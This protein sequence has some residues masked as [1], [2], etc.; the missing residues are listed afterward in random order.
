[1]A[2]FN[3]PTKWQTSLVNSGDANTIPQST[4]VGTGEASFEDGFPQITQVP[5]GAGGIAP[6][7]KDFNGLFKILG[8]WIFFA[9]NGGLPTYSADFDYVAGR[10]VLYNGNLY[11]CIQA[12]GASSTVVAPDS[13]DTYWQQLDSTQS[14]ST[15]LIPNQTIISELPLTDVNLHLKDG[16]LL[17]GSG[18]YS[19][20]VDLIAELYNGGTASTSFC[21]EAEWQTSNTNYGFCNKFVYDSV[22]NTVRLPKVNSEHGALI[23]SYSS[24]TEWYRIY[25]DGWCEQGGFVTGVSDV[26]TV[27][28]NLDILFAD[29]S[30]NISLT[31]Y[32]TS[33]KATTLQGTI[34]VLNISQ[35]TDST[36]K[37]NGYTNGFYWTACGY[38]DISDLQTAPI[39]EYIVVG[40]VSKTDIQIDIDNILADLALKADKDFSN[41]TA[42]TQAF[43]DMSIGWDRPDW[44]AV[45]SQNVNTSYT[46]TSNGFIYIYNQGISNNTQT[47]TINGVS[48][49]V[50]YNGKSGTCSNSICVPVAK[51]DTYNITSTGGSYSSSF[52]KFI[53]CKGAN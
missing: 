37:V 53:P 50:F 11:K 36:F 2:V 48:Q 38:T 28:V 33:A 24:E 45:I 32:I 16:A 23:K 12:N 46:A 31:R 14:D 49:E 40:T 27:T 35:K 25:Q 4:P 52:V 43:K 9:Q 5:I 30:Y 29:T 26:Q 44:S 18:A 41:V 47:L 15:S 13:D 20:Y 21:T 1:M 22:N 51:D 10:V 39:Y 42:P 8:D 17:S 3:E 19:A 34:A 6:D 7:R